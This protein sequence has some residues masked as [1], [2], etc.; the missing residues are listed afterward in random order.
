MVTHK[1]NLSAT[2]FYEHDE[3]WRIGLESSYIA[4]QL[5]QNYLSVKNYVLMAAI[6][7][8]NLG[9]LSFILNGENLGDV[10]QSRYKRIYDGA[11]ANPQFHKLW[12]PIDGRLINLSEKMSL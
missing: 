11:M 12:T 2:F 6:I 9:R 8:Y 4:H 10:R 5:N 3:R 1:H 7:Q